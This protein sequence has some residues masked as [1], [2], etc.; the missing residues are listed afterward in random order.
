[1]KIAAQ[2]SLP[3]RADAEAEGD[4]ARLN[5]EQ[6][7]RED[8]ES[9]SRSGA[10]VTPTFFINGRKY[11]GPW[12]ESA[13]SEA[14]LGSLGHRVQTA[15]LDFAR[16]A[17]STGILLLLMSLLAIVVVNSPFGAAFE[18]LWSTPLE[19]SF[20]AAGIRMPA[21]D[22]INHGLLSVFFL[23]VGLE[24]K[25]EFTIGHLATRSAAMLPIAGS[26]GGMAAPALIYLA[27]VPTG[28]WTAGWGIP[29]ATD[30]A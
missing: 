20:G 23:V 28:T 22:W 16:W 25:R 17:P 10:H 13:L 30:T 21:V 29:I 9:A 27:L 4:P 8:T 19:I 15:A 5:A 12:D 6:R 1:E 18:A 26:I 7:V 3:V 11:E 24:I 2:F 14:M